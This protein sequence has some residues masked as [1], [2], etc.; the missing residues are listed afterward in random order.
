MPL[1]SRLWSQ[2]FSATWNNAI[3]ST[4]KMLCKWPINWLPQ[5]S[6]LFSFWSLSLIAH[7]YWQYQILSWVNSYST[8]FLVYFLDSCVV[9]LFMSC[10]L[11]LLSFSIFCW[12]HKCMLLYLFSFVWLDISMQGSSMFDRH[13]LL[14]N[15][16]IS[17]CWHNFTRWN[18]LR[19]FNCNA[20]CEHPVQQNTWWAEWMSVFGKT[21]SICLLIFLLYDQIFLCCS[22]WS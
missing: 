7:G 5:I 11:N 21:A 18:P 20:F 13:D 17:G 15:N 12:L 14:I 9:L 6:W 4:N 1:D 2:N 10:K 3:S 8:R 19:F 22:L 16:R